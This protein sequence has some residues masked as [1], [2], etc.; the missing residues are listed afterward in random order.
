MTSTLSLD[1]LCCPACRGDLRETGTSEPELRCDACATSYPVVLGIP[2]LRVFAD[3]YI[4]IDAD[5]AKG[6]RIAERYDDLDFAGLVAFYYS[7][8]D[9]VPADQAKRF[10]AGLLGAP[11]R[12][13]ATLDAW[14]RVAGHH[15]PMKSRFIEIGCGTAPLLVNA[16]A[17]FTDVVGVDIA[18]RW[19][20]VAKKRLEEAGRTVPLVCACAEALPLKAERWDIVAGESVLEVTREPVKAAAEVFRIAKPG[21][22]LF[23]TTPNRWSVGPDPHLGVPAGGWW[24]ASWL[25]AY[26]RRHAAL[27]PQRHLFSAAS[28]QRL[29]EQTGFGDVRLALPDVAEAQRAAMPAAA[30]AAAGFYQAA[31]DLPLLRELLLAVGPLLLATA[32]RPERA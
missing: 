30:G 29:L 28:M 26:A 21:G 8:T 1:D 9:T 17:R 23:L 14:Q 7:I 12:A 24:P 22:R 25:A 27:P 15:G 5:R 19:L 31:K 4:D 32:R 20:V 13:A 2:D 3:P 11:G 16:A 6:R 18:F 10:T